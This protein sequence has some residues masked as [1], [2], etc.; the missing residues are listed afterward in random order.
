MGIL[1]IIVFL[2]VLSI[3]VLVH[4]FGHF[5]TARWAG[6]GVEEFAMGLPFTKPIWTKKLKD[7]LKISLYPVLFGGFV[8][9][10]GEDT[11]EIKKSKS[12]NQK[13]FY[14][15]NV[16]K[17][18]AIVVAGAFM[19]FVLAFAVFYL[20]LALSGFKV[21]IPI[22]AEYKFIS[23]V[24]KNRAVIVTYV[25]DKAPAAAAGLRPGDVILSADN[26]VFAKFTDF[27][28]YTKTKN[29]TPMRLQ[30]TDTTLKES[31]ELTVIPRVNPPVGQ[32]PLGI[33]IGEGAVLDYKDVVPS[34]LQYGSDMFIYNF[35][36]LRQLIGDAF[37]TKN[38][39]LVTEGVSGPIGIG[40]AVGTILSLGGWAAVINMLNLIGLLG[41]S[42]GFMNILPIP[43]MDGGR[44]V[45]LLFEALTG[46][47]IPS[48]YESR[49]HQVGMIFLLGLM[50]LISYFDVMKFLGPLLPKK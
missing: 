15:V 4:E 28:L 25:E 14:E 47:S 36:V 5:I 43:A 24:D 22:L 3:L 35:V 49:V 8:K 41:L 17:R 44:L 29:G 38:A 26:K 1:T 10:L 23:P 13:Y 6:V 27:Q 11:T 32:G 7:G 50:V 33:G 19:N 48:K 16:W 45:F 12:K 42:L 46:R 21:L 34:G 31:K 40:S 39:A 18:I 9:L 30:L 37:K 20:F 2:L